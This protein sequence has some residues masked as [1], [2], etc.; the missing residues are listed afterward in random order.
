MNK[1]NI[2]QIDVYL[3]DSMIGKLRVNEDGTGFFKYDPAF[4]GKGIEPSPI[5]MPVNSSIVYSFPQLNPSVF[6]G[7]PGMIADSLPDSFGDSLL[8]IHLEKEGIKQDV[9]IELIKLCL[10]GNKAIGALEYR[11]NL[12]DIGMNSNSKINLSDLVETVNS[13]L[14]DKQSLLKGDLSSLS[15]IISVSSS[16]GGA[17]PKAVLGIDMQTNEIRAGNIPLP[18]NFDYYIIK[19]DAYKR[20]NSVEFGE[21]KGYSNVEY[22]YHKMVKE[23]NLTMSESQLLHENNRSHFLTKRFDRI[24]G[25]KVHMQS[26]NAIAHMDSYK[27]WDYNTYFR[28][29]QALRLPYTDQE[30]MYKRIV[31]NGLAGNADTHT[32]NTSFLMQENGTWRLSP[33][34]DVICSVIPN[35][36]TTEL[37]KTTINGK[38]RDFL[39]EDFKVV[40]EK[41]GIKN[42]KAIIEETI[43]VLEKWKDI[44]Q[45]AGVNEFN[46]KHVAKIIDTNLANIK[47]SSISVNQ[48]IL[49]INKYLDAR[50][51]SKLTDYVNKI[52]PIKESLVAD[53]VKQESFIQLSKVEKIAVSVIIPEVK[54][55]QETMVKSPAI[56]KEKTKLKQSKDKGMSM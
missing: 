21:S 19:F 33:F 35:H 41:N 15:D 26:L 48:D 20:N 44:S 10:I 46:Q 47:Y 5:I 4:I 1:Q 22:A 27:N 3:Y 8:N 45:G 25:R 53:I 49:S 23:L 51:W 31:F 52:S 28:V 17:A 54:K 13:L 43:S 50:D 42:Y 24:D 14:Y 40:A 9:N 12:T 39:L 36:P 7:M 34:Y 56:Q 11:P 16:L 30:Q 2:E 18:S 6:K 29:M 55:H 37:H 38:N 32:K